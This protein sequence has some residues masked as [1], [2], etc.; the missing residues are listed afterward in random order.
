MDLN[1]I[2]GREQH[3][4]HMAEASTS[5]SARAAHRAFAKAYGLK[6]AAS[7]FPHAVLLTQA[8]RHDMR[9]LQAR[10]TGA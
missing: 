10:P 4:L 6:L 7:G 2:L 1:Y 3:T 9:T 8:E 5:R